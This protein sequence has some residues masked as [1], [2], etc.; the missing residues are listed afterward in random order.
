MGLMNFGHI[1]APRDR[2]L[3]KNSGN[4]EFERRRHEDRGAE[5]WGVRRGCPFPLQWRG[6]ELWPLPIK[7]F[8]F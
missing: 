1:H 5:G 3:K 8:R 7:I 4:V 2:F 6:L